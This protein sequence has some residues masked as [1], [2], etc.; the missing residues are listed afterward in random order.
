MQIIK[1]ADKRDYLKKHN[2]PDDII[3]YVM[4]IDSKYSV[5]LAREFVRIRKL[6]PSITIPR[7]F[8]PAYLRNVLDWVRVKHPEI[9][10]YTLEQATE[11]SDKWHEELAKQ[12][13]LTSY[14]THNV[15]YKFNDGWEMVKLSSGDCEA[16]GELMGHCVGSYAQSVERGNTTIFSLRDPQNEPHATIET[17]IENPEERN[18]LRPKAKLYFSIRQ[19]QGKQ[20]DEPIPEYKARIKEW[21]A[22]LSP[23]YDVS[24]DLDL[25]E[26][27]D[28]NGAN[29]GE[30]ENY[31]DYGIISNFPSVGGDSETYFKNINEIEEDGFDGRSYFYM[32]RIKSKLS[33][34]LS[35]ATLRGEIKELSD[36]L[37]KYE[38]KSLDRFDEMQIPYEH[39]YPDEDDFMIN[40]DKTQSQ[41]EFEKPEFEGKPLLDQERYNKAVEI[42]EKE[43]DEYAAEYEPFIIGNAL[44][45][46][47][48]EAKKEGQEQEMKQVAKTK[49]YRI[50]QN[51]KIEVPNAEVLATYVESL[52][53]YLKDKPDLK[54][55]L[56]ELIKNLP[57]PSK[58]KKDFSYEECKILYETVG[59][60]WKKI[61]GNDIIEESHT[62][63]A[64]ET[65]LGNYWMIENG[66]LLHGVNHFTI[67]KQNASI[68]SS[69]LN[70][71]GFA[72]QQYLVSRPN[73]L[74]RFILENGGI[75]V[76]INKSKEAYFQMSEDTY[77]EWGRSKVKGLDFHKKIVKVIDF[78]VPY[79]GWKS[80]VAVKL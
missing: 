68:L 49:I 46:M 44:Y 26:D 55:K 28:V 66:L 64:P 36:G 79:K 65:L 11:A 5:W 10:K 30:H 59:Y 23:T 1:I 7:N 13:S 42:Y 54:E 4:S 43:R 40:P 14:N 8:S 17:D 41:L 34:L 80:G 51:M 27:Y 69:L 67:I 63:E 31:D 33:D 18:R 76:F 24:R 50:A 71:N 62:Q 72:L 77:A 60:L 2:V 29:V 37:Q 32:G 78:R 48:E 22:S 52:K 19:I 74:I 70:V 12:E 53:M 35:Y 16:E 39:P 56:A 9:M 21:F 3:D 25:Y 45:T 58:I 75:R 73:K 20:N 61:T 57:T 15:V 6:Q 38:E 47:I